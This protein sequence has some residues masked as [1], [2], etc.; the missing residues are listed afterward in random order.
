MS[1]LSKLNRVCWGPLRRAL[2]QVAVTGAAL[3]V[4]VVVLAL[5]GPGAADASSAKPLGHVAHHSHSVA[6]RRKPARGARRKPAC[7]HA[8][9]CK[10]AAGHSPARRAPADR[11]SSEEEAT[12]AEAAEE[13][14]VLES[15]LAEE[16]SSE[17]E[18]ASG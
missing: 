2:V 5:S 13:E 14:E 1:L 8:T 3:A 16:G 12:G 15:E 4:L 17:A 7:A 18:E 6:G 10:R 9:H 11:R